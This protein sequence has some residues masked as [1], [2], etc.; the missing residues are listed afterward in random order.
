MSIRIFP[1]IIFAVSVV[2]L[3]LAFVVPEYL[4]LDRLL[5]GKVL[6]NLGLWGD[7]SLRSDPPPV[8]LR[9]FT[10]IAVT[11]VVLLPALFV[12]LS[13]RYETNDRGWAYGS[14]AT[15]L[16]AWLKNLV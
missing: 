8:P 16:A 7:P 1:I 6:Y 13:K 9:E 10:Q 15:I 5:F 4:P 12:I 3:I 14:V 2:G 11:F